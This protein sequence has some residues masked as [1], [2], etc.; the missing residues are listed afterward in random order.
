MT[1]TYAP[2]TS[3]ALVAAPELMTIDDIFA[4]PVD[5]QP[6]A[7][8][9]RTAQVVILETTPD[10]D[11][12]EGSV[13]AWNIYLVQGTKTL[14]IGNVQDVRTDIWWNSEFVAQYVDHADED[15]YV[16]DCL[17]TR[18]GA[19]RCAV[20]HY[21]SAI[22]LRARQE[23]HAERVRRLAQ[24]PIRCQ[25]DYCGDRQGLA[26][27]VIGTRVYDACEYCRRELGLEVATSA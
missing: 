26:H 7:Y 20:R 21:F 5:G 6:G 18:D 13:R 25:M 10:A 14:L 19:I 15:L 11:L 24:A 8:T 23:E 4:G 12:Y 3:P 9:T 2:T 27:V 22:A 16:A 1:A 17:R